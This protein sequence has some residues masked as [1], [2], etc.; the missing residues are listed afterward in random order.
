[1]YAGGLQIYLVAPIAGDYPSKADEM[2]RQEWEVKERGGGGMRRWGCCL[3]YV[4][5]REDGGVSAGVRVVFTPHPSGWR[6][7]AIRHAGIS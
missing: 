7:W 4:F 5:H 1:M 3:E 6:N 2:G